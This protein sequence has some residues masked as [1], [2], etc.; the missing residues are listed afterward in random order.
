MK[1]HPRHVLC[2]EAKRDLSVLLTAWKLRHGLTGIEYLNLLAEELV[3]S[4]ILRLA[5]ERIRALE[6]GERNEGRT[7][8]EG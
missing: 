4:L 8:D 6:E 5:D 3:F 7:E 2:G 1:I